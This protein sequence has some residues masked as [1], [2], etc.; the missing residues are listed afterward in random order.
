MGAYP[1]E[2]QRWLTLNIHTGKVYSIA[3]EINPT[4]LKWV[5]DNYKA[6]LKT[7]IA[8]G[9]E[10]AMKPDQNGSLSEEDER[11][12]NDLEQSIDNL[13]LEEMLKNYVFTDK[14]IVFTT[15]DILPY[16]VHEREPS[17]NWYVPYKKL[18]PYILSSAIVLKK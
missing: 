18:K 2:N 12:Y 9:K 1:D 4:G 17:R 11:M 13:E 6:L 3:N 16:A 8:E 7:R 14:G 10:A 15:D 5:F